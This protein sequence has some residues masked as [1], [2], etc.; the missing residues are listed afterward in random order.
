MVS[1]MPSINVSLPYKPLYDADKHYLICNSGRISG[2]SFEI[3][4]LASLWLARYP[5]D[6]VMYC[7]A[8]AESIGDSIY[9]ELCEKVDEINLWHKDTKKPYHIT[10]AYGNEVHFKGLDGNTNRTKG[11]KPKRKYSLIIID[12]C[13]EIRSELNLEQALASFKRHLD[14]SVD[15]KVIFAGNPSEQRSHWWN[16]W[17]EKHAKTDKYTLIKSTYKDIIKILPSEVVEDIELN[18]IINPQL[19]RFMYLGDI[20][21]LAGGAYPSF[22]REKHLITQEQAS[23]MFRGDTIEA[24]IFGTDG[25]IKIDATCVSPIAVMRSGRACVLERFI[26]DPTRTGRPLA[27]IQY[28][29]YISKYAE[30]MDSK[31]GFRDNGVSCWFVIDCAAADLV[32]QLAYTLNSYFDVKAFTNK[33]IINNTAVVN[34]VFA[35]NMC[36]VIDYGGYYDWENWN[37]ADKAPPLIPTDTDVL[38]AQLESVVWKNNKLD[39]A[40]PNDCSDSLVYGLQWYMNPE[41]YEIELP[42]KE[43]KY[44]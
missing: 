27:P 5:Q 44:G 16:T 30:W 12:E 34:S 41:N 15:W 25:A 36:Y 6:D 19:A 11:N 37:A 18:F 26:Y 4:R 39:P 40:V 31:Y 13:E 21:D 2:K 9:N 1:L 17:V 14:M 10:T 28:A 42:E 35:R 24:V 3:S 43:K 29:E 7:R 38:C 8:T 23:Q 33:S 22:R 32:M 20:T